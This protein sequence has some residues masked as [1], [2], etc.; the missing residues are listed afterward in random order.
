[1]RRAIAAGIGVALA[2]GVSPAVA[3]DEPITLSWRAPPDCP[4]EAAVLEEVHRR[5][6]G[7]P[8]AGR[9]P[10]RA[11]AQVERQPATYRVRLATDAG[12][13]GGDRELEDPSCFAL[14]NAVALVLALTFDPGA[15]ASANPASPASPAPAQASTAAPLPAPPSRRARAATGGAAPSSDVR[16]WRVA[17]H[18]GA[19]GAVGALPGAAFGPA[20][21]VSLVAGRLRAELAASWHPAR[22]AQ[23]D[24]A[25]GGG[26]FE[27]LRGSV[28]GCWAVLLEPF[29]ASPCLG[30][31]MGRMT[32]EG[33]GV[34]TTG[35]ASALWLAP[36]LGARAFVP[37]AGQAFGLRAEIG[38]DVPLL[39]PNFVIEDLDSPPEAAA[40][41][42]AAP[43]VGRATAGAEVR[44]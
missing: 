2:C 32:G 9:T 1:M 23:G 11:T 5:L 18:V 14:G 27:L 39:R 21:G 43:V 40:V 29:E 42:R 15:V 3:E 4:S 33:R 30:L 7:R 37:L 44:F 35:A 24:A 22:F 34:V 17:V 16:G 8:A 20:A 26:D 31:Q 28:G 10:L 13:V 41:H 19:E 12:G 36:S 25:R 38:V 6:G